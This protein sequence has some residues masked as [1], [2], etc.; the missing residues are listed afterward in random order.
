MSQKLVTIA[1]YRDLPQAGLDKSILEGQGVTCFLDNEFTVGVNWLYSTALGGVKLKVLEEDVP[2][3]KELLGAGNN[4]DES[5]VAEEVLPPEELCPK[6]ESPAVRGINYTRKF[7][8]IS[9][10]LSLPFFFFMKRYSCGEC[11]HR[12][13]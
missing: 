1:R 10:L 3:A 8:A 2:L 5:V 4:I 13:R 7:A 9:L 12:W 11:G 6:C